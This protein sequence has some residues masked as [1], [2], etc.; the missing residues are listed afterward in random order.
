MRFFT[1]VNY[2]RYHLHQWDRVEI[3]IISIFLNFFYRGCFAWNFEITFDISFQLHQ[4]VENMRFHEIWTL[5]LGLRLQKKKPE[6]LEVDA[7]FFTL[8][9][10]SSKELVHA[11][12]YWVMNAPRG[13]FAEHERSVR[14]FRGAA[15]WNSSFWGEIFENFV[16][17]LKSSIEQ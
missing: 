6:L 17:K 1:L 8:N 16:L 14:V 3:P 2:V 13:M 7:G 5:I 11:C 15:N 10:L 12:V 9:K 4:W